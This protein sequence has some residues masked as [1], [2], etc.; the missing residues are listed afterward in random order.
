MKY[1]TPLTF[2][3]ASTL[4]IGC[5]AEAVDQ[6]PP[7]TPPASADAALPDNNDTPDAMEIAEVGQLPTWAL[8]DIQPLS[9]NF[10][11]T[12]GLDSFPEKTVVA[13]LVA[14]F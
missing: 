8:R 12:Y 3:I 11:Q 4:S 9:P 1:T 5:A 14:G 2:L 7:T 6:A 13:L 10:D